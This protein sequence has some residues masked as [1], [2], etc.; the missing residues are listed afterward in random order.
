VNSLTCYMTG[1]TWCIQVTKCCY[2][3]LTV[4]ATSCRSPVGSCIG[5]DTSTLIVM[6]CSPLNSTLKVMALLLNLTAPF[7]RT[8]KPVNANGVFWC[9]L[10]ILRHAF[11]W[12]HEHWFK[13]VFRCLSQRHG[14]SS[15]YR[16]RKR[17][18]VVGNMA[19]KQ[20]RIANTGWSSSLGVGLGT[21][22]ATV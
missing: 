19:N 7:R 21:N 13:I 4:R 8:S 5:T 16:R 2:G 18:R 10:L 6:F 17:R 15:L 20:S 1:T 22:N 3:Y 9:P 14:A 11:C 12:N